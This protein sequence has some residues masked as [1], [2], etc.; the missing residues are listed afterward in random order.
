MPVIG[1]TG[2][3]ASGKSSFTGRLSQLLKAEVFDADATARELVQSDSGVRLLLQERFGP[4]AFSADGGVDRQW[5][6]ERVFADESKRRILEEILHPA[7]RARWT[8]KAGALRGSSPGRTGKAPEWLLLDIP[9]L[10]EVGAEG[11][12]DAV[13]VVAC[14]EAT[15]IERIVARRGLS[16]E[17]ACKMIASQTSLASKAARA[18]YVVW[19]DA[20]EARL[21]EQ[22]ELFARYLIRNALWMNNL[23]R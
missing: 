17:M 2:G 14:R 5:L 11:Q 20:P 21:D 3:I 19:N 12:C 22:A 8:A 9:L 7:I 16:P 18:D 13:V 10:Y 6:R 4:S 15:Q 1:I 23:P